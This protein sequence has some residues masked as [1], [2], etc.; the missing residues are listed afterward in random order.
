MTPT[1][2]KKK[3]NIDWIAFSAALAL[4]ALGL[5]TMNSFEGLDPFFVRQSVWILLGVIV[6]FV[7]SS[8][9]WR[10]LRRSE[11][12]AG[13]YG[14]LIVP[15]FFLI[16]LGTA[17][18]GA[19][20]W[21]TIGSFGIEPVE[22][23]ALALIIVLA[24]YFSRRHIEIRD[25]RHILISGAYAGIVFILVALQPDL[26]GAIIIALMWLG[27]VLVSGISRR[28][29]FL[30]ISVGAVAFVGLWF[31]GLHQYQKQ[32][33]VSFINPAGDIRG[34][35]Y[36]AY[37]STVAVGSGQFVGKGIGY[38]TQSKLRFLPEYQTDFIFA[39]FAEEWGFVGILI[40]F[41]L[42]GVLF[43]RIIVAASKGASNFETLFALGVLF[44]FAAHFILHAGINMGI[45][46]VTGTTIPFMS[47][48][49]SHLLAEFLALGMLSGMSSYSRAT[50]PDAMKQE[51]EGGYDRL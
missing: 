50:H 48:G 46:P 43:W 32:R 10:F 31:F 40:V 30:V 44:Y 35:G 21:L 11:V 29:L 6:F 4:C 5:L 2:A 18:K 51:F 28:H 12:A 22:F 27:M 20:S 33:I 39:A 16:A 25:I 9:D 7:A 41:A 42:F 45:L 37:Q 34:T 23:A 8:V 3:S 19:K 14:V 47:Y 49:G 13:I 17:V 1:L 15:L 38:G 36:N 24:K 26:G